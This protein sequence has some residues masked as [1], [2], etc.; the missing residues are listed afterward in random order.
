MDIGTVL[1]FIG[2]IT[3]ISDLVLVIL[4]ILSDRFDNLRKYWLPTL[5]VGSVALILAVAL[6][7]LD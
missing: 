5:A 4:A 7:G 6:G 3:M 1:F 2:F